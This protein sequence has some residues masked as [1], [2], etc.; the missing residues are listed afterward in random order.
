LLSRLPASE[1]KISTFI[2]STACL[3]ITRQLQRGD[4]LT[5]LKVVLVFQF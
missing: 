2:K 5:K 4:D 1:K 3:G